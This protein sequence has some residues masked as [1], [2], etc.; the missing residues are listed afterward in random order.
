M[1]PAYAVQHES[2]TPGF[3]YVENARGRLAMAL[4]RVWD[5]GPTI[6]ADTW[7]EC[8]HRLCASGRWPQGTIFLHIEDMSRE[9]WLDCAEEEARL[10]VE[11]AARTSDR[12]VLITISYPTG[13]TPF[14][15]A[16][17]EAGKR[18]LV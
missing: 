12:D 9:Q 6:S 7:Q 11:R 16:W 14:Y 5:R 4:N 3:D 13:G 10:E 18:G 2:A 1:K 8:Q 15:A 17:V